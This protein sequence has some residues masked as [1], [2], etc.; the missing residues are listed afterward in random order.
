MKNGQAIGV[1]IDGRACI[2]FPTP[3]RKLEFFPRR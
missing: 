3:S 1:D 2:G